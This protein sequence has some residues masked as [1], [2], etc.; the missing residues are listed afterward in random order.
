MRKILT[1]LAVIVV[2]AGC[3]NYQADIDN[4]LSYWST[5]ATIARYSFDPAAVQIDSEKIQNIPSSSDVNVIL[6]VRNPKNFTFKLPLDAGAPT[7]IVVFPTDVT[8]TAGGPPTQPTD[9]TLTQGSNSQLTLTYKKAFLQ[10]YEYGAKNIGPTI[11]LYAADDRPFP[12]TFKLNVKVNTPPPNLTYRAIGKTAVPDGNSK[13]YYVL[14]LE[15]NGMDTTI[16]GSNLLHK[17]IKY[18]SIAEGSGTYKSIPLKADK[19]GF[20]ISRAGGWLLAHTETAQLASSDVGSGVA[21][22]DISALSGGWIVR[23]KTDVEVKSP[24]KEYR[25]WLQDE[26][27]LR[28]TE[29][30]SASTYKI[31]RTNQQE[32]RSG[33]GAWKNLKAAVAA[34]KDGDV[35]IIDGTIKATNAEGDS[36][37]IEITKK[38]TIK[39]KTGAGTDMLD[40]NSYHPDSDAPTTPH[41]IFTIKSGGNLTLENLTLKNGKAEGS[42]EDRNGGAIWIGSDGTVTMTGCMVQ[43]CTA[44]FSGGGIESKGTLTING[45]IIGS[46]TAGYGNHA[47]KMGGGIFLDTGKCTFNGVTVQGN[48]INTSSSISKGNGVYLNK[49]ATGSATLTVTGVTKIGSST[50]INTLCL[51]IRSSSTPSAFVMAKDLASGS[52][53]N[54]EPQNYYSQK[55]KTLVKVPNGSSA[56]AYNTYFHLTSIPSGETYILN[57]N[58]ADEELLLK[59]ATV[60]G[61]TEQNP[62]KNLKA[63]VENAAAGDVII[64]DGT[65]TATS[66]SGNNGEIAVTKSI[67]IRGKSGADTDIL[68]AN[69]TNGSKPAHRIFKVTDCNLTL[70]GLTLKG[71]MATGTELG[72]GIYITTTASNNSTLTLKNG[73]RISANSAQKGGGIAVENAKLIIEA[74]CAIGGEQLYTGSDA[75]KPK[76]N[77]TTSSGCG[78]GIYV[79]KKAECTIKEGVKIQYNSADSGGATQCGGG[80]IYVD[81]SDSATDPD[82]GELIVNGTAANPVVISNCV[83]TGSSSSGGG[84]YSKGKVTLEYAKLEHNKAQTNGQGGGIY[85]N[86]YAGACELDNT[87][88]T[89]CEAA[90]AGGGVYIFANRSLTLK[91]S[92]TITFSS[93]VDKGKGDVFL[94]HYAYI[95]ISGILSASQVARISMAANSYNAYKANNRPVLQGDLQQGPSHNYSK[96]TVT[97]LEE[98]GS[99]QLWQINAAG[100]LERA[101]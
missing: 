72:G 88:I 19:S 91:G 28:S 51:A 89:D 78:G 5:Q 7:D 35:I 49:P 10:K 20:D 24:K 15:A 25:F 75:S 12:G 87:T 69:G 23:V 93:G 70:E 1:F 52:F 42:G 44:D 32:I 48:T 46:D 43:Q 40:A 92:T 33:Q 21:T 17:D 86:E 58:S 68:N 56:A 34:A 76:G 62:W 64:V 13:Q 54:I 79:G 67:T 8:G 80:G 26:A 50:D 83:V 16:N 55:D 84:I 66:D 81:S 90:S 31:N 14:F 53:I 37:A 101:P 73:V 27:G 4:Y 61:S 71:G 30:A 94:T 9:Y 36:G 29:A 77:W 60:I 45:G 57:P 96:F 47:E 74:G 11:R 38:I 85:I 3:K 2:Y 18:L 22:D 41:R 59:E 82:K 95:S 63:A 6:T 99:P 98:G 97:P 39:G 100:K 65:I